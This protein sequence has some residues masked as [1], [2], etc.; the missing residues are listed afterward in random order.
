VLTARLMV[1]YTRVVCEADAA[2]GVGCPEFGMGYRAQRALS[3]S[4]SLPVGE[5]FR[6]IPPRV[7][8]GENTVE[9]TAANTLQ[10]HGE[11]AVWT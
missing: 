9:N 11:C 5:L 1:G 8:R 6:F 3:P 2:V 4:S 7:G 10:R